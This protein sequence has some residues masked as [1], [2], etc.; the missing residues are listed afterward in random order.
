MDLGFFV[1]CA[2]THSH[3]PLDVYVNEKMNGKWIGS[4]ILL[5]DVLK[6]QKTRGITD[7]DV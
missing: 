5:I 1:T 2:K 3:N 6:E 7:E 4:R